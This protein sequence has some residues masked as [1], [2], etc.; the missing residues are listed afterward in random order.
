MRFWAPRTIAQGNFAFGGFLVL[1]FAAGAALL[2][3]PS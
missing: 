2:V 3:L 1:I